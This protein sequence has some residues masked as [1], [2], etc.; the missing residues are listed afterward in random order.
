[1]SLKELGIDHRHHGDTLI[2]TK[3]L[4][5]Q[6]RAEL[7]VVLQ[8]LAQETPGDLIAGP[9]LPSFTLSVAPSLIYLPFVSRC[10][11]LGM[12]TRWPHASQG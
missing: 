9:A 11:S 4:A 6:A 12:G 1:M 2:A 10:K 5:I 8:Q 7:P 3:R